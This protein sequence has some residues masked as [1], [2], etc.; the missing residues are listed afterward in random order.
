MATE[1]QDISKSL[2]EGLWLLEISPQEEA[3]KHARNLLGYLRLEGYRV[4]VIGGDHPD[5]PDKQVQRDQCSTS[6]GGDPMSQ[7]QPSQ[8]GDTVTDRSGTIRPDGDTV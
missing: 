5:H 2:A 1:A 4:V 7:S 3:H 8:S 6:E